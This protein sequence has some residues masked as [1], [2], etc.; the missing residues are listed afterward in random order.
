MLYRSS[1]PE[2]VPRDAI[3]LDQIPKESGIYMFGQSG[4]SLMSGL[5][6]PTVYDDVKMT[7]QGA[8]VIVGGFAAKSHKAVVAGPSSSSTGSDTSAEFYFVFE[9]TVSGFGLPAV[10]TF[11]T[12]D[13]F[14]L[15]RFDVT[16]SARE[17]AYALGHAFG[18]HATSGERAMVPFT[19]TRLA[20]GVYRVVP[21]EFLSAGQYAF[22]A[23]A[24][25][26][27]SISGSRFAKKLFDFSITK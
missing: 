4:G 16:R 13:E 17:I 8:L 7:G 15:V 21:D 14:T 3:P 12:A 18:S 27:T 22:I 2:R 23:S 24:N 5:I 6:G 20:R 25:L 9:Q 26:Y 1:A 11:S 19:S 10:G